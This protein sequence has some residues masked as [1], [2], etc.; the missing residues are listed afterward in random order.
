M[1][2]SNLIELLDAQTFESFEVWEVYPSFTNA[3]LLFLKAKTSI[4][5][6]F[7]LNLSLYLTKYVRKHGL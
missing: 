2:L 4:V 7:E 1:N 3:K 6:F 5:R